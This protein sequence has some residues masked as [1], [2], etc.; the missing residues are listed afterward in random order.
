MP[1]PSVNTKAPLLIDKSMADGLLLRSGMSGLRTLHK[2]ASTAT[3]APSNPYAVLDGSDAQAASCVVTPVPNGAN[4]LTLFHDYA[5]SSATLTTAPVVRVYGEVPEPIN[6]GDK[7]FH[8]ET[9][10]LGPARFAGNA[11]LELPRADWVPLAELATGNL[12]ITVGALSPAMTITTNSWFRSNPAY[13]AL[14]GV[15]RILVTVSTAAVGTSM[16]PSAITGCFCF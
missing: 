1:N 7:N 5:A 10:N 15:S 8:P 14:L 6:A 2:V 11:A 16:T 9:L 13:V 12:A 3:A 4:F